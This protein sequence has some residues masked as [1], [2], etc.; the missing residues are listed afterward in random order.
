LMPVP[1]SVRPAAVKA[2]QSVAKV[3]K[4]QSLGRSERVLWGEC[5]GSGVNPYQVR[6]DLEDAAC[7]CSCPSR[8]LPC[9]HA[10]EQGP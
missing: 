6:V 9:K 8:K 3:G 1:L 4:W 2:A 5:Y 10:K 7:K